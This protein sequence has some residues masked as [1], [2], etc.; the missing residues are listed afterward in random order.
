MLSAIDDAR[1][2]DLLTE[3]VKVPSITGTGAESSLQHRCEQLLVHAGLTTGA[4]SIDLDD[5]AADPEFPGTEVERSEAYGIV[6]TTGGDGQPALILQG[7]VDVVPTGDVAKWDGSDPF[8]AAIV[9]G[10]LHGRGA[11]DMKGGLA[12]ILVAVEAIRTA[13]V[14]LARPLAVH[15]V[16]SEEDG[17]LGAFA[18]MR[19]GHRGDCA[20]IPEPTNG[21]VVVANAGAL[22]FRLT[23]HGRA[24][25]GSVRHEGVS[26][27]AAFVPILAALGALEVRRNNSPDR[28]FAGLACPYPISVGSVHA[29]DW[30]SSVPDL[31]TAEG[32]MG[33]I[34][35]EDPDHA[36]RDGPGRG[37]RLRPR[38]LAQRASSNRGLGRRSICQRSSSVGASAARRSTRRGGRRHRSE[39]PRAGGGAMGKRS[40]ALHRHRRHSVVALRPRRR[41]LR[42]CSPGAG[43][44]QRR[45]R[46]RPISGGSRRAPLRCSSRGLR[47]PRSRGERGWHGAGSHATGG[48]RNAAMELTQSPRIRRSASTHQ[49]RGTCFPSASRSSAHRLIEPATVPA[50]L[51]PHKFEDR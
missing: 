47:R 2:V 44:D 28:L 33:V 1:I 49:W 13:G 21:R 16:V 45:A 23:V 36:H 29:G 51:P 31:L 22:T 3:L 24:A 5:L 48:R 19:R 26:A 18:T 46:R 8:S 41:S 38:P 10:V 27:V 25:H 35:G 14:H 30:A 7:H 20:V 15:T 4:W 39:S 11:C 6:G 32:R 37:R 34:L 42:P 9:G 50:M 40:A 43:A 17:G 12:A